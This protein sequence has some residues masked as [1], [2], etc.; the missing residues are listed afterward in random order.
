MFRAT[1]VPSNMKRTVKLVVFDLDGVLVDSCETHYQ[2]LNQALNEC[3]FAGM[4]IT[5]DEHVSTYNGRPTKE[6]LEILRKNKGL[7]REKF[8]EV[9][10]A[11]QRITNDIVKNYTRDDRMVNILSML[12]TD[13][14][15]VFCASNSIWNT[16]KIIL[17]R[18]GL[19]DYIDY[20]VSNEDV[21]YSKPDPEIYYTCFQRA[22][23]S[24]VECVILEDSELG[25]LAARRSGAHVLEVSEPTDVTY[26]KIRNFISNVGDAGGK[27][28]LNVVIPMA[29]LGSRFTSAGYTFPKPLIEVEGKPMIQVVVDN[30]AFRNAD[31][32][33]IFIV[34]EEHMEQY[35]LKYL[36]NAIAPGCRIVTTRETTQGAACTVLL[37][38]EYF[39]NDDNLVIANSDQYVEFDADMFLESARAQDVDGL[40]STFEAVHPKWSYARVGETGH[41]EEVAEK[42]PIS[43]NAT[44]GIYFWRR[45]RE[46]ARYADL[47]IAKEV[48][49]NNEFY[50]CPVFNEAIKDGKVIRVQECERMWGL[51]TPEDLEYFLKR[52]FP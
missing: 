37:A 17:A 8:D 46:F 38:R 52:Q 30:L 26:E 45:G 3:G 21:K 5:R 33:Y 32:Q 36:L 15:Q 51:G 7:P 31:T 35:S 39:E 24:P 25:R 48:R 2:A 16:V 13:G 12:K 41:V 6:K 49:V 18:K 47:M 50:V 43:R 28:R 23:V 29:G 9:W 34:R 44:T 20:F 10:K 11:K 19:L 27:M 40:I 22:R 4:T 1:Y 14:F 42:N